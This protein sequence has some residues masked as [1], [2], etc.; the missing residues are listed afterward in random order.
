MSGIYKSGLQPLLPAHVA[1]VLKGC[2]LGTVT[3]QGW[4]W[5]SWGTQSPQCPGFLNFLYQLR[6]CSQLTQALSHQWPQMRRLRSSCLFVGQDW[7]PWLLG[8]PNS[9][10]D[11]APALALGLP[12]YSSVFLSP[13]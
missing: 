4:G 3:S 2:V 8:C 9:N 5:K 11:L 1:R 7:L 6:V 13:V 12:P 10:S